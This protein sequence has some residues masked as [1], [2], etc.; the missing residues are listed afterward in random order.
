MLDIGYHDYDDSG[1]SMHN[2]YRLP[3][4]V[5]TGHLI[6]LSF[7]ESCNGMHMC[8]VCVSIYT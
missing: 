4:P 3:P 2:I 7:C 8:T 6:F 5:N 1:D